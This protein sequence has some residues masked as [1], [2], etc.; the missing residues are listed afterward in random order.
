MSKKTSLVTLSMLLIFGWWAPAVEAIELSLG[1]AVDLSISGYLKNETYIRA[2]HGPDDIMSSRNVFNLDLDASFHGIP[3]IKRTFI[4]L[5]PMYDAVFDLENNG[6]G[7]SGELRKQYQDNFGRNDEWD[8]L[9]REAWVDLS[10]GKLEARLGRQL[11]S[12]GKSDGVWM[13][14]QINPFNF[15]NPAVFEEEDTKIPLWMANLQYN[16]KPNHTLQFLFIPRY[17]PAKLP[18][19]PHD[20]T[21][22]ITRWVDEYYSAFDYTFKN[23][24]GI[25]EGF[26]V[27]SQRPTTNFANS[28]YGVRWSGLG[29]GISYTLNYLYTWS[30]YLN[31]YPNTGDWLTATG[32]ERRADRLSIFGGAADYRWDSFLGLKEMV[33]RGE[34]AYFKNA[35]WY[36]RDFN[37]K[38]KDYIGVLF[39]FDKYYFTDY[40][41]S[42]QVQS[43]YILG[44]DKWSSA[45]YDLGAYSPVQPDP[46]YGALTEYGN[47]MRNTWETNLTFYLMKEY[48][49]G[50]TLHTELFLLYDDDGAF[51]LR[52][53]AKYDVTDQLHVSL[54]VNIFWGNENSP[55]VGESH[56]NDNVFV[57]FLWGF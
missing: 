19:A 26:S 35:V 40:W 43:T 45:Y 52:P 37:A 23:Y 36:D 14:D 17:V 4:K 18:S 28:E 33:T 39:G 56:D 25:P 44:A 42:F 38:E 51:W 13:L 30:D 15:R 54:G 6:T 41:F 11:V 5:R 34:F 9:L 10:L 8:P 22:N 49:P 55:F 2:W 53:K 27:D 16:V 20:W 1:E 50:D 47:G 31:D 3:I 32:V 46:T 7:G 48:L 24:W 29:K 57:E 21:P 12:W